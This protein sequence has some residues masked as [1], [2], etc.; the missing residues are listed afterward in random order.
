MTTKNQFELQVAQPCPFPTDALPPTM[1]KAVQAVSET[2]RVPESL[3]ACCALAVTSSVIGK[4]LKV[5]SIPGK[6]TPANLYIIVGAQ[7]GTGKSVVFDAMTKPIID[8]QARVTNTWSSTVLPTVAAERIVRKKELKRLEKALEKLT[9]PAK[10]AAV[11]T[12]MSQQ[13]GAMEADSKQTL[14]SLVCENI[15]SEALAILLSQ[16]GECL[17]SM[18]ADARDVIDVVSGHYGRSGDALYLKA[19]S[20]DACEIHR[21]TR[22]PIR[23]NSPN[24]TCLWLVQPDKV[25]ELFSKKFASEG[26]LLPR[27]L[28]CQANCTPTPIH[29]SQLPVSDKPLRD[30]NAQIATLLK[31][32]RCSAKRIVV[33]PASSAIKLLDAHHNDLVGRRKSDLQFMDSYVARWNEQAW[34]LALVLHAGMWGPEAGSKRLSPE[35]ARCAITIADWFAGQ[36]VARLQRGQEASQQQMAD[37]VLRLC[38]GKRAGIKAKDVYRKHLVKTT[39]DA[40]ELLVHLE[41]KGLLT[42]Q[43]VQP[44]GGGKPSRIYKAIAA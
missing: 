20:E 21:V 38:T 37:A 22:E 36:Q 26:G 14:Q 15:T 19:F 4:G 16:N 7:S 33:T 25:D 44:P 28:V 13:I 24:L 11:I 12:Q 35:T 2:Y 18:S 6:T 39:D 5:A 1:R 8:H 10:R 23:L 40:H 34:R 31:A 3:A 30:W 17:A 43:D 9:E 32:Y 29:R 41:A 27:F 42:G